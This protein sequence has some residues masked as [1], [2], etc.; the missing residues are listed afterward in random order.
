MS[1]ADKKWLY[2]LIYFAMMTVVVALGGDGVYV[3]QKFNEHTEKDFDED[4]W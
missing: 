1:E 3:R 4:R 2:R